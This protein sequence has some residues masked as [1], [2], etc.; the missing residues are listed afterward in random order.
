MIIDILQRE[1]DL[2]STEIAVAMGYKKLTASVS[3]SIRELMTAGQVVYSEPDKLHSRN[4]K[5]CLT[6]NLDQDRF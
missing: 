3:H 2:S 6:G 4:Q 1:G 5:I